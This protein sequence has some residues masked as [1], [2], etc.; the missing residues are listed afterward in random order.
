[1]QAK[2]IQKNNRAQSLAE[3]MAGI[4]VLCPV[5]LVLLDLGL[6][7]AA[8]HSNAGICQEAVRAAAS[9]APELATKRA[10]AVV[11]AS[12]SLLPGTSLKIVLPVTTNISRRPVAQF[13]ESSE[14]MVNPGGPIEGNTTVTTEIQVKPIV[15]HYFYGGRSPV[16]FRAQQCCPIKYVQPAAR[17][18]LT[19]TSLT[20]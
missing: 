15:L 20:Q 8:S 12:P 19:D 18:T 6:F 16:C 11:N 7:L 17:G 2:Y 3:F 5:F 1:M 9:G 10:E 4:C 14:E 13:D